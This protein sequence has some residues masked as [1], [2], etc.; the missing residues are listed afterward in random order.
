MLSMFLVDI[1]HFDIDA[2]GSRVHTMGSVPDLASCDLVDHACGS[3]EIYCQLQMEVKL[4]DGLDCD[5]ALALVCQLRTS[6]SLSNHIL[7]KP[8][9]NL[10]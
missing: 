10:S 1:K 2:S 3:S 9:S 4:E 7:S 8:G 5:E 6:G